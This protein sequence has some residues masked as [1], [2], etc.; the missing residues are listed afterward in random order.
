MSMF[1]SSYRRQTEE[2]DMIKDASFE[3]VQMIF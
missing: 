2:V 3:G 1:Y